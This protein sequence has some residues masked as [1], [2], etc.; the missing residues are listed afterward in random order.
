MSYRGC[1]CEQNSSQPLEITTFKGTAG[2]ALPLGFEFVPK[3]KNV[4][5]IISVPTNVLELRTLK[6]ILFYLHLML[7]I[8]GAA[9]GVG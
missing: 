9:R 5:S 4:S 7:F 6:E 8:G 1:P 3:K 2:D